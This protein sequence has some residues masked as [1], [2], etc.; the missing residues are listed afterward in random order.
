M[1]SAV[2]GDFVEYARGLGF[3]TTPDYAG[4]KKKFR[5][6]VPELSDTQLFDGSDN[7]G[8]FVG[9]VGQNAEL[10]S[11]QHSTGPLSEGRP[12]LPRSESDLFV[13]TS[14]WLDEA[15]ID[16][17]DLLGDEDKTVHENF[18][19]MTETPVMFESCFWPEDP[20]LVVVEVMVV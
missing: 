10:A 5:D 13:P 7:Q 4:W 17:V 8:P 2:F 12:L 19:R 9:S 16:E 3:S 20:Q 11:I 1:C 15:M 14:P 18:E 6:L